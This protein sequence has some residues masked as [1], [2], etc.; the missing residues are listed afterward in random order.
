MS[1]GPGEVGKII[2][3]RGVEFER[4]LHNEDVFRWLEA[5]GGELESRGIAVKLTGTK[6]RVVKNAKD[7]LAYAKEI[8]GISRTAKTLAGDSTSKT[9]MT[10]ADLVEVIDDIVKENSHVAPDDNTIDLRENQD[11][12]KNLKLYDGR[13]NY[14]GTNNLDGLRDGTMVDVRGY[15]F[16][17][18]F[19][20][21]AAMKFAMKKLLEIYEEKVNDPE[22]G[23][24]LVFGKYGKKLPVDGKLGK[25]ASLG[26]AEHWIKRVQDDKRKF[27][28]WEERATSLYNNVQ[29]LRAKYP[30]FDAQIEALTEAKGGIPLSST[31]D[32]AIQVL[33][34][35]AEAFKNQFEHVKNAEHSIRIM[36]WAFYNDYTG[37]RMANLLCEKARE[38]KTVQ[39]MVDGQVAKQEGHHEMFDRMKKAGVQ[40]IGYRNPDRPFDGNHRKIFI[41][42]NKVAQI[43]GM[44]TG[45]MYSRLS[46]D[47][48]T[49][50]FQD[51]NIEIKGGGVDKIAELFKHAW[52]TQI[53]LRKGRSDEFAFELGAKPQRIG[54]ITP[55]D[56][57]G[58]QPTSTEKTWIIDH[59]PGEDDA[60]IMNSIL[61]NIEHETTSIDISQAYFFDMPPIQDA[62]KRAINRGVKI[63]ILGNGYQSMDDPQLA[64]LMLQAMH[65]LEKEGAAYAREHEGIANPVEI[66]LKQGDVRAL[67]PDGKPVHGAGALADTA[68]KKIWVFGGHKD[69]G[70]ARTLVGSWNLHPRS[71]SLECEAIAM[72]ESD[73]AKADQEQNTARTMTASLERDYSQAQRV[74][75]NDMLE[76]YSPEM[77]QLESRLLKLLWNNL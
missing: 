54:S 45:D 39:V 42:D 48:H 33:D 68:H 26:R 63:R 14:A 50:K 41:V 31:N 34:D 66:Y 35:G 15:R 55:F 16:G 70:A 13:A 2:I 40:I 19:L 65:D 27:T 69:S 46:L 52:N 38:G 64:G 36:S 25:L 67:G 3:R 10:L 76:M 17:D 28:H 1:S 30:D 51:T 21:K 18:L 57:N 22:Y 20:K 44:N 74:S 7:L 37:N 59:I 71:N 47:P 23:G 29:Q 73:M 11:L 6:T 60:N 12:A 53:G 24:T 77:R 75:G 58:T 62:L 4:D 32:N 9:T 61:L 8:E 43:G 5:A 72:V 56:W 49:P